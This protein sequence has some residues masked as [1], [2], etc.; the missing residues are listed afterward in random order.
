MRGHAD[1]GS[2]YARLPIQ[3]CL[4]GLLQFAVVVHDVVDIRSLS[5]SDKTADPNGISS[6]V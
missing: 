1:M 4:N 2:G 5:T 3:L 6:P